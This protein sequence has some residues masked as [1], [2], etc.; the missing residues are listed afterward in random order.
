MNIIH[1]KDCI[2]NDNIKNLE[3]MMM[4][5]D[6]LI[7]THNI[8]KF[9]EDCMIMDINDMELLGQLNDYFRF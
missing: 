4:G 1:E 5:I 7:I 3:K 2:K 6:E 8:H 9:V